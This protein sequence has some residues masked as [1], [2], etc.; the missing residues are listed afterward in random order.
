MSQTN[1]VS[2]IKKTTQ[3]KWAVMLSA[4]ARLDQ[5]YEPVKLVSSP[6]SRIISFSK[7]KSL[8]STIS[9]PYLITYN[10][11]ISQKPLFK[12][13]VSNLNAYIR[14]QL[15]IGSCCGSHIHNSSSYFLYFQIHPWRSLYCFFASRVRGYLRP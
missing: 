10:L 5:S 15:V 8:Y 14:D 2:A 6:M 11:S 1:K 4:E 12:S 7:N 3:D 9:I 13:V